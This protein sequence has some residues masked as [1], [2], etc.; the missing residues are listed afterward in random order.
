MFLDVTDAVRVNCGDPPPPPTD[1]PEPVNT[2][3]DGC[4]DQAEN[5]PDEN[6]GGQRDFNYF[7]DFFDVWTHPVGQP[8]VFER[9]RVVNVPDI[10]AVAARFGPGTPADKPTALAAALTEPVDDTSY[11][12]AFDRGPV[13][14]ANHW[15]RAPADG[16][17]NV[18]DDILGI[19][20]QF[21]HNCA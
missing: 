8:L 4:T 18:P 16:A 14:G 12:P 6:L 20:Q 17:I 15:D 21:G 10:V 1:T 5:G 3:Q 9:N 19:A 2:D 7:W 13:I 11:H